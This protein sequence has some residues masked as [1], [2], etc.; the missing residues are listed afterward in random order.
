MTN[1]MCQDPV[2]GEYSML[3]HS[4]KAYPGQRH[5]R[6]ARALGDQA[7]LSSIC[8]RNTTDAGRLDYAYRP[9]VSALVTRIA[10][11]LKQPE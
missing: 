8:A 1:P 5:V 3:Q 2:T 11:I 7:V 9:A 4:G 10:P 6:L